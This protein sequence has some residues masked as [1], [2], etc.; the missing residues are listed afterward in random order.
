M[1]TCPLAVQLPAIILQEALQQQIRPGG[2]TTS[3]RQTPMLI[4]I[5][6]QA[7]QRADEDDVFDGLFSDDDNMD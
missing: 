2:A 5:A 6:P 7:Y 4:Q 1:L 3:D